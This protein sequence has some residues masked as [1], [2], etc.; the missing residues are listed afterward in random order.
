[1][2]E[3]LSA[4]LDGE[5]S[6][7]ELDRLLSEF[8]RDPDLRRQF[9]RLCLAREARMGTRVRKPDLEFA[10]RVLAALHSDE[11]PVVVAIGDRVRRMPWRA[12]ASLAAAAALGAV[13]VLA[14]RPAATPGSGPGALQTA[15]LPV[16]Q[17]SA[18]P[19]QTGFAELDDEN[20]RQLRNY[21]MTY[22][23]LRG[24]QSVGATLGYARYAAYNDDRQAMARP[25][26]LK[27]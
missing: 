8:D 1:M 26:D 15:S 22:S 19:T 21:L 17:T 25:A 9:A 7:S 24:Q 27:R 10:D 6:P 14:I 5:C 23:Q 3:S 18:E 11:A 2:N 20:A 16:L 4:L 13:A 12:A